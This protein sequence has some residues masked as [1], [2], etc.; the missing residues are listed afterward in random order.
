MGKEYII[1]AETPREAEII[2]E[3]RTLL[4]FEQ[5]HSSPKN[6][7]LRCAELEHSTFQKL[8]A[9][10]VRW[11]AFQFARLFP[12]ADSLHCEVRKLLVKGEDAEKIDQ[13]KLF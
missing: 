6:N 9:V 4:S 10:C 7:L 1:K 8:N 13:D 12:L 2:N 11:A 3:E 5:K